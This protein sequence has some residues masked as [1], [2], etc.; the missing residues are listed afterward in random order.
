MNRHPTLLPPRAAPRNLR[1]E[2]LEAGIEERQLVL[3][4]QPKVALNTKRLVGFEALV[5]WDHAERGLLQPA[6]FMWL[7]E[8]TRLMIRLSQWVVHQASRQMAFWQKS[9]P[10]ELPLTISVNI[11]WQ[12]LTSPCLIPDLTRV[13]AD[14]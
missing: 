11:S 9:F 14:T 13:L 1:A 8:E 12:Y 5:R 4:Y 2:D 6:E 7:A 10:V 3:H